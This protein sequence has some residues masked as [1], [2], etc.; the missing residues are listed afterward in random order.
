MNF[1]KKFFVIAFFFSSTAW[2]QSGS[3]EQFF[4][5]AKRDDEPT[6]VT[7][8]LRGLD[9]NTRDPQGNSA[10]M[11]A[12][13]EGAAKVTSFLLGLDA[14]DLEIRNVQGENAL[15]LAAL[16]G[17]LPVVRQMIGRKAEVNK[18][19][20]TPLHY[21]AT[22]KE[23]GAREVVALL[24]EHHAYIDAESPNRT[25]PLMM[26]AFYGH[27]SVV[28]LLLEEGADPSL[29]NEKGLTA[30]DFAQRASRPDAI[31]RITQALRARQPSGRW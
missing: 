19:G 10:L 2:A 7:L 8:V 5:A 31:E 18:P 14:V 6:M 20:W 13:R 15:M 24:L 29:R 16:K 22:Y 17:N 26:A 28:D 4:S 11:I 27:S 3:F 23:A 21:A 25:T 30:L 1:I 9:V 12:L